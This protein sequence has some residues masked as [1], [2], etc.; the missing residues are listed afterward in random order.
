LLRGR[1][2]DGHDRQQSGSD[3]PQLSKPTSS[4]DELRQSPESPDASRSS[5]W[6]A[7]PSAQPAPG[8]FRIRG[9]FRIAGCGGPRTANSRKIHEEICRWLGRCGILRGLP[10]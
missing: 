7:W 9:R 8:C 5:R 2:V 3:R 6:K 1:A 4:V 10:C